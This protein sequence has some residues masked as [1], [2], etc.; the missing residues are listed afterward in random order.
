MIT[1]HDESIIK[2]IEMFPCYSDTIA[3]LF[4]KSQRAANRRLTYLHNYGCIKRYREHASKKYFYWYKGH[5]PADKHKRHYDLV[6]RAFIWVL[7]HDYNIHELYI[8][9]EINGVKPDL[10]LHIEQGGKEN[11]LPVEV[12]CSNNVWNTVKKYE[13]LEFRKLLLF[14]NRSFTKETNFIDVIDINLKELE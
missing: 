4:Y 9:K 1:K 5:Q 14:C 12:E 2:F 3:K 7:K 10:L 6:A 11:I 8:Q 13:G